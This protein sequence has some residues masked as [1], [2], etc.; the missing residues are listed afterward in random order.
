MKIVQI[1][2]LLITLVIPAILASPINGMLLPRQAEC[3]PNDCYQALTSD[4]FAASRTC[5]EI[6]ART[7]PAVTITQYEFGATHTNI[8]TVY[9]ATTTITLAPQRNPP[10]A[11][12]SDAEI[13]AA[14]AA[15]PSEFSSACGCLITRA[16]LNIST[17]APTTTTAYVTISD[18]TVLVA[19][20]TTAAGTLTVTEICSPTGNAV[21]NED[22]QSGELAP[23]YTVPVGA[24]SEMGSYEIVED[25]T[26]SD[27]QSHRVFNSSVFKK[28]GPTR[29][30]KVNIAQDVKTCPG[31]DYT[32]TF[33]YKF[34][35]TSR[36]GSYI[37]AFIG[38]LKVADVGNGP[39]SW[40]RVVP[41]RFRA[42]GFT[43][44]LQVDTVN[45][46]FTPANLY[47]GAFDIRPA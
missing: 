6:L 42:T 20:T 26:L 25:L 13:E 45:S 32:L 21:L 31:V 36:A 4:L 12:R 9:D 14:C 5:S 8:Q 11:K 24:D 37:V 29:Y 43:T 16:G 34:E 39:T 44:R 15:T 22:F 7:T 35:G 30:S 18:V 3:I 17:P 19:S 1:S 47:V 28:S 10:L 40:T 46:L 27:S 38:G 2:G 23:W 41:I 33:S